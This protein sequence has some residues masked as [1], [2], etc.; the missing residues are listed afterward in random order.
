MDDLI[1]LL[2]LLLWAGFAI[3]R[4]SARKKAQAARKTSSAEGEVFKRPRSILEEILLDENLP[5]P[6]NKEE[7][8]TLY[9]TVLAEA[10][11]SKPVTFED[12][13]DLLGIDSVEE[14]H[15]ERDKDVLRRPVHILEETQTDEYDRGSGFDLRKAV[16]YSE[17][18][19][20]RYF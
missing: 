4:N 15:S 16:V 14:Q 9:D 20:R 6:G 2:F 17:I 8:K 5:E 7:A 1:Y 19:N 13:Y 11:K 12:E 10:G 3:Y 18:L